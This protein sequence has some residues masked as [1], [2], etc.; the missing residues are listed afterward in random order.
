MII[1][2]ETK[3]ETGAAT[4]RSRIVDML[5]ERIRRGDYVANGLPTEPELAAEVGV[6]RTT[7]RLAML[8][9]VRK[10]LMVRKPHGK[11]ELNRA[12][13]TLS[14]GLQVALLM[15]AFSSA[16]SENWRFAIERVAA[17]QNALARV[18]DFVH[19][20]DPAIPRTLAGFDGVFLIP[21]CEPIS[22]GVLEQFKR[23]RHLVVLDE[24]LSREGIASVDLLPAM[25]IRRLGEHLYALGHRHVD[26]LNTQPAS[27]G[28]VRRLEQWRLWQ[29][30]RKADGRV[31]DE[32][33]E[34]YTHP[35][36]HAYAVMKR[37][38]ESGEFKA[39]ALV[40]ITGAAAT[41]AMRA[42][43]EH[44]L[45]VGKDVSV[46]A[47]EG[48]GLERY[49][50]VSLTVLE[51]V[52][53]RPYLEVF[54]EWFA[55]RTEPWRGPK[56]VQPADLAVL[57]GESTGPA[58]GA[59]RDCLTKGT[60]ATDNARDPDSQPRAGETGEHAKGDDSPQRARGSVAG[61]APPAAAIETRCRG[62]TTHES[63]HEAAK[64][65]KDELENP[66]AIVAAK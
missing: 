9:L 8:D 53:A 35:T 56:L 40:C 36:P 60:E 25:F 29:R 31:I 1:M 37:L 15:P 51:P 33:V 26:C 3:R 24:D 23:C 47:V 13:Q 42:L 27:P 49:Q 66:G 30:L 16:V 2:P 55:K 65:A 10:G 7:A 5:E 11:L 4:K 12:H 44:G 57:V 64:S 22:Q 39:T 45:E 58:P 59:A 18:V 20:D 38:L 52:D 19:W 43:R 14:N 17:G 28:V 63:S 61:G 46:C 50:Y 41:G 21:S 6:S 34:S 32:P 54:F 48:E 62:K